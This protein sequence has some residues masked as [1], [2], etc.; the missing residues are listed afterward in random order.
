M[1]GYPWFRLN[2]DDWGQSDLG[3]RGGLAAEGAAIRVMVALW[4]SDRCGMTD[5]AVDVVVRQGMVNHDPDAEEI[6]RIAEWVESELVPHPDLDGFLTHP[7]LYAQFRECRELSEKRRRAGRA[8]GVARAKQLPSNCQA[9]AKQVRS[10]TQ[11]DLDLDKDKNLGTPPFSPPISTPRPGTIAG[12]A[13]TLRVRWNEL[14]RRKKIT[15]SVA[16]K[17][18]KE[19]I[20]PSGKT[21]EQAIE[22][23]EAFVSYLN[24]RGDMPYMPAFT[25]FFKRGTWEG[26]PEEFFAQPRTPPRVGR[27]GDDVSGVWE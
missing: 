16:R 19:F 26:T 12:D 11:A 20:R 9:S 3:I 23:V 18:V 17:I 5:R 24:Q 21:V 22:S 14:C 4:R 8:G 25:N 27:S 1:Q 10:K 7:S 15:E 6:A 13:R 2:A